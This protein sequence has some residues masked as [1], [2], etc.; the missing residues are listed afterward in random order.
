LT[1]HILRTPAAG[2]R[3][4][5]GRKRTL[6]WAAAVLLVAC[7]AGGLL[8]LR[9]FTAGAGG[10]PVLEPVRY[11]RLLECMK[12]R[13]AME[14]AYQTEA[15]ALDVLLVRRKGRRG[16]VVERDAHVSIGGA[17]AQGRGPQ[18]GLNTLID[19]RVIMT[20]R[21]GDGSLDAVEIRARDWRDDT[22]Y[23]EEIQGTRDSAFAPFWD[24]ALN[25]IYRESVCFR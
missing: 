25:I 7:G 16:I 18:P 14:V 4:P 8:W 21:G 15:G 20:D 2:M 5:R 12:G 23:T 24:E 10:A 22:E 6:R 19:A 17:A 11:P 9:F 1:V 13:D 3:P